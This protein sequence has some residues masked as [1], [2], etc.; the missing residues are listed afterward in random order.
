MLIAYRVKMNAIT[1]SF[2]SLDTE[3]RIQIRKIS[4]R[5]N[6]Q[7]PSVINLPKCPIFFVSQA[8]PQ[9]HLL[10]VFFF[11][12]IAAPSLLT[13]Y[14]TVSPV[15]RS[16]LDGMVYKREQFFKPGIKIASMIFQRSLRA[17]IALFRP[18]RNLERF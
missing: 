12:D 18:K 3:L 17:E 16:A 5:K 6:H 14:P 10:L 2:G 1:Q 13:A 7:T 15:R 11:Y 4:N 9:F 8:L